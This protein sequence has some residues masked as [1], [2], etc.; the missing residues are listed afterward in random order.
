M[1]PDDAQQH[2]SKE[3]KSKFFDIKRIQHLVEKLDCLEESSSQE[4]TSRLPVWRCDICS[5]SNVLSGIELFAD[6][7]EANLEKPGWNDN[8]SSSTSQV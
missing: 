2:P 8:N 6:E 1:N 5:E 7:P 4:L 3:T